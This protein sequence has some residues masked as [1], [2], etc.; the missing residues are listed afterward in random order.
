MPVSG[1]LRGF[2]RAL[3]REGIA[4]STI[5]ARTRAAFAHE[6]PRVIAA[7]VR[8]ERQR[9]DI[10][11]AVMSADKRRSV[12]LGAFAGCPASATEV[13]IGVTIS[14]V[15]PHT[16]AERTRSDSYITRRAGRLADLLNSVLGQ[17]IS[18]AGARG[19]PT[20][21]VTSAM[22]SGRTS[23]VVDYVRCVR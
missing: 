4:P 9:Q 17:A 10:A 18:S 8:E 14:Y 7:T 19:S 6:T 21:D 5:R 12:D 20:P 13:R 2:V 3:V 23:Y 16:G 1:V 11:D 15:D 22:T